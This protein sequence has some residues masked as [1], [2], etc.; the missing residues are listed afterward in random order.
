MV[1][2]VVSTEQMTMDRPRIKLG[3]LHTIVPRVV[4]SL[5]VVSWFVLG[6][7]VQPGTT[8]PA[9]PKPSA[10]RPSGNSLSSIAFDSFQKRDRL[11]AEKLRRIADE[12]NAGRLKYDGPVMEAIAKAGSEASE[13]TWKPVADALAKLLGD[14]ETLDAAKCEKAIRELADGAEKA[15]M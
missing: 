9:K 10:K 6:C 1:L 11:R 12:V 5:F 3:V 4:I 7:V 14:G 15:G 13:E 8:P 2:A